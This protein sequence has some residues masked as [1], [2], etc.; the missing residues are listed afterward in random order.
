MVPPTS[1]T[2]ATS[3]ASLILFLASNS[4]SYP[5]TT[6]G[7]S[8]SSIPD[9]DVDLLEFPLN[10]EYLE[11]E[12]APNLAQQGA[13]P[14]GGRKANL[15]PFTKD[16]IKQFA[17]QEV[18]H[19]RAIKNAVKGF[20]RPLLDLGAET[21]AQVINNAFGR[22]LSPTFDPYAT[23]LNFLIACYMIP[24]VGL[25][26]YVGAN[27]KLQGSASKK[28]PRI[29]YGGGDGRVPGGFFPQGADGRIARSYLHN[30]DVD[31]FLGI[32]C[33][34]MT[35]NKNFSCLFWFLSLFVD[36]QKLNVQ[37]SKMKIAFYLLTRTTGKCGI[38]S[39]IEPNGIIPLVML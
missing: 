39:Y 17:W 25:T 10:L 21:F 13:A 35:T 22:Q 38:S 32:L 14:I 31:A 27:P 33:C 1:T 2:I 15:D 30:Y 11:A 26:G 6:E 23:P 20:P 18:E 5:P 3:I 9:S 16:V 4:Y 29:V 24:Y 34:F 28:I 37:L 19:L 36:V 8:Y 7:L 12:F